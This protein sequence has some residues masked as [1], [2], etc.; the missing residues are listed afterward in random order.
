MNVDDAALNDLLKAN[1]ARLIAG[2]GTAL[3]LI[4]ITKATSQVVAGIKYEATG[5]FKHGGKTTECVI[6]I[7]HRS[8]LDDA[9][10]KTKLKAECEGHLSL[11]PKGDD[12]TW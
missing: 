5:S 12:G 9:N 11:T 4:T 7:W 8:W 10:E 3:E 1:I 6:T 2:D